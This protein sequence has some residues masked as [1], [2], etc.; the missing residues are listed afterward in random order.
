M[1]RKGSPAMKEALIVDLSRHYNDKAFSVPVSAW[2][3][4][5]NL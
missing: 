5:G 2:T 1:N 3:E 4:L